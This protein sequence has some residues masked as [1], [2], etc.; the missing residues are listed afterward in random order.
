MRTLLFAL[1][2]T[3]PLSAQLLHFGLKGGF[4][5]N[6][7]IDAGGSFH[8]ASANWTIGPTAEIRLP[9]GFAVEADALYRRIGYDVSDS[10]RGSA[11]M[12][13]ILAKYHF[14]GSLARMYVASG[15]NLRAT[16]GVPILRE[17]PGKGFV[18]GAGIRYDLKLIKISPELRW[19]RWGEAGFTLP[20][21]ATDFLG[22]KRNQAEFLI[23]I[24]F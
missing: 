4:P 5:L 8:A 12:F 6:D 11:W 16:T 3:A 2:L 24:S 15:V 10:F 21:P 23:G 22:T 20:N 7:A 14:P 19:T 9:L 13:P 17:V 1:F 18:L